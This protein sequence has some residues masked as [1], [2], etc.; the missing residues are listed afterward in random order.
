MTNKVHTVLY[1]GVTN[2]ILRRN[3]E[4]KNKIVE[5]FTKKYNVNKLVFYKEFATALEA[6]AEEKRIKGWTRQKKINLINSINSTWRD[7]SDDF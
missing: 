4:H 2:N 1:T 6:I 3:Y 5:G 7:L